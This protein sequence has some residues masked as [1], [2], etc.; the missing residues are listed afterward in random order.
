MLK[1]FKGVVFDMDGVIIDSEP[2]WRKVMSDCFLKVGIKISEEQYKKTQGI[3]IS[4]IIEFY[5]KEYPWDKE[6]VSLCELEDMIV[7]LVLEAIRQKNEMI[8]GV[9]HSLS[10][11]K[12]Q[13]CRL[14]IASSSP[15]KMIDGVCSHFSLNEYFEVKCSGYDEEFGK[16]NPAVYIKSVN[17][18]G[19]HPN[20]C[21]AIEDSLNGIIA[22]KAAN[23]KCIAIP[24]V[25]NRNNPKFSLSDLILD[26]L[27][28][29]DERIWGKL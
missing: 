2:I 10:F 16:P 12:S 11:F 22:A 7:S 19:L 26:N 9:C 20:E 3:R 17:L 29:I 1:K 28:Q 24:E 25:I 23:M 15:H 8:L 27:L 5:Y 6:R 14:A 18:L 4:E 13:G 21:L